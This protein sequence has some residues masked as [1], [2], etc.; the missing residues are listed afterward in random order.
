MSNR[1]YSAN[2]LLFSLRWSDTIETM[3][4]RYAEKLRADESMKREK[5]RKQNMLANRR[6]SGSKGGRPKC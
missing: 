3:T 5:K 2:G 4:K 6:R 1:S